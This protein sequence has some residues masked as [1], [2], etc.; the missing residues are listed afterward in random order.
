MSGSLVAGP[1]KWRFH[2]DAGIESI[3]KVPGLLVLSQFSIE[4]ATNSYSIYII[5]ISCEGSIS[6]DIP[7]SYSSYYHTK[8]KAPSTQPY[9]RHTWTTAV[10]HWTTF[11]C[12]FFSYIR[13]VVSIFIR[14]RKNIKKYKQL[15]SKLHFFTL[16]IMS[17]SRTSQEQ[18]YP[19]YCLAIHGNK[20]RS[21]IESYS[22]SNKD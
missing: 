21:I 17:V 2:G 5:F 19:F 8:G 4:K 18:D 1:S 20:K 15:Y 10:T 3:I 12:Y 22:L 6:E 13:G 14:K 7:M 9:G 11:Q 16:S